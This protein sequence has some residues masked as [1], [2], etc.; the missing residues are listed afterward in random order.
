MSKADYYETLG[1]SKN[2]S[3][4]E[5]KKAYR[6]M[7]M[8]HHPDRNPGDAS[9][10]AKFKE[11]QDAWDVLSDDQ[12]RAAY[13]QFG[14]AGVG[15]AAG[16]GGGDPF[17][18]GGGFG[19]G[20]G[21][22]FGDIFGGGG[23]GRQ[24]QSYRGADLRYELSME[25]EDAVFG[26]EFTIRIPSRTECG[27][28][29]GSG[30]RPGT[31]PKTCGTC[32]GQGQVRMQQGFFSVQ[33]TCP[34]CRG[35]GTIISDPCGDCNGH[36]YKRE[37]KTLMVKI[38]AGVDTGDR[39]RSSGN[40]EPGEQGGPPG[41]LLVEVRV[42]QHALFKRDGADLE[43]EVPISFAT[44]TLGGEIEVPTL[45]GKVN[46][47]IPSE[48]QSGKVFRLRGKGVTPIR[49]GVTGDLFVR[50]AVEVPV[51]LTSDQ[52][53][54]LQQFEDSLKGGGS[55]HSPQS[56]GWFDSVKSFFDSL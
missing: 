12:K 8:K 14:H 34:Q 11:A 20:F 3:T 30:A 10:E 29:D 51:K 7:A 26:K 15:G 45:K 52:K 32:H 19:G 41:D 17:G 27:T 1:V 44:A 56:K 38:P 18:G 13:D 39:I 43:C 55:R 53:E 49:S 6:R 36:G 25:L 16:G 9:A 23:G 40:G 46:I 37:N 33:Q 54:L 4:A 28:C 24:Q 47:K 22:I 42:K 21:D 50:V 2:A 48:T 31:S 5:I 35:N